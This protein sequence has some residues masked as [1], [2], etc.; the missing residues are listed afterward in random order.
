MLATALGCTVE[1]TEYRGRYMPSVIG[2][3]ASISAV[4]KAQGGR[5]QTKA[6]GYSFETWKEAAAALSEASGHQCVQS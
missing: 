3:I 5:W 4:L 1:E 2:R 6:R